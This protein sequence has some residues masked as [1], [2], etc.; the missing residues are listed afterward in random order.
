M[1]HSFKSVCIAVP[2]IAA[3][4]S[5]FFIFIMPEHDPVYSIFKSI[6]YALIVGV[7]I[8]LLGF[9]QSRRFKYDRERL[10]SEGK[11]L[12]ESVAHLGSGKTSRDGWIFFTGDRVLFVEFSKTDSLPALQIFYWAVTDIR[13]DSLFGIPNK[14][15]IAT[16]TGEHVFQI[17]GRNTA[18]RIL[19]KK[20]EKA[21]G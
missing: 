3:L 4:L 5:L 11:I 12:F 16:K 10:R 13:K 7:V 20:V 18:F 9:S 15:I 1:R 19:K 6:I 2:V 21:H 17:S 14:L 8:L